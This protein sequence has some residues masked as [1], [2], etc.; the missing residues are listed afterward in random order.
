MLDG[1]LVVRIAARHRLVGRREGGLELLDERVD[2]GLIPRVL[3]DHRLEGRHPL[4]GVLEEGPTDLLDVLSA[5]GSVQSI[6]LLTLIGP[7]ALR[8]LRPVGFG[9]AAAR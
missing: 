7:K 8:R 9:A 6:D 3:L 2:G 4:L 5:R 1:A